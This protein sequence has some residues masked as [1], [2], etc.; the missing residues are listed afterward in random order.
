MYASLIKTGPPGQLP[1]HF[2]K[3][4]LTEAINK[5][6]K[7]C[8]FSRNID[9]YRS[10]VVTMLA[11]GSSESLLQHGDINFLK[12]GNSNFWKLAAHVARDHEFRPLN[13]TTFNSLMCKVLWENYHRS[14]NNLLKLL[15]STPSFR[16]NAQGFVEKQ[17]SLGHW[18]QLGHNAF[19]GEVVALTSRVYNEKEKLCTTEVFDCLLLN[20]ILR[21]LAA[22]T[23]KKATP[24]SKKTH[25]EAIAHFAVMM[26]LMYRNDKLSKSFTLDEFLKRKITLLEEINGDIRKAAAWALT[27]PLDNSIVLRLVSPVFDSENIRLMRFSSGEFTPIDDGTA[28]KKAETELF[29]EDFVK[30]KE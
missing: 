22:G 25:L 16:F 27:D 7:K 19:C 29:L 30:S 26:M 1:G 14:Q 13:P 5:V 3:E 11:V 9:S 24:K 20:V 2:S 23:I 4:E 21:V 17:N 8:S 15:I 12:P 18:E 6:V 28:A 10:R